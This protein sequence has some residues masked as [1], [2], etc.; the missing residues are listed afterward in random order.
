MTGA[1]IYR[2]RPE[3]GTRVS[4]RAKHDLDVGSLAAR[5]GGGGHRR[6][7]GITL[8]APLETAVPTILA[9]A[10]ELLDS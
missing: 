8:D 1:T 10:R 2:E 3:G 4:L 9:A 6:A 5:F 7:A